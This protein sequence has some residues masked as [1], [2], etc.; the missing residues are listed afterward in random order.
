MNADKYENAEAASEPID[1]EAESQDTTP[2]AVTAESA[3]AR[4]A[5]RWPLLTIVALLLAI[6]GGAYWWHENVY[7]PN[8]SRLEANA[9][10]LAARQDSLA[11]ELGVARD[12][13]AERDTTTE[14]LR[15]AVGETSSAQ[16]E[17]RRSVSRLYERQS[18]TSV[19]WILA[20]AEYLVL[21]ASQRLALEGDVRTAVAALRAADERLRSAE[22][23]D[24]I[25]V[26]NQLIKDI[27]ALE[28]VT[29]PDVEGIALYL[30]S[31]ID[32][33]DDLP[34]KPIADEIQT[35]SE[36]Q[37]TEFSS[38]EPFEILRAMW[39]DLIGLVEVKDEQLPD[40]VLFDPEL[41]YFLQQNLKLE[42]ASARLS[43]LRVD[44][45]NL[46]ASAGLIRKLLVTYY[47][48]DDPRVESM[49]KRLDEIARVELQPGLPNISASLDMLRASR[50]DAAVAESAR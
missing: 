9:V 14:A 12:A 48:V 17:L 40:S 45:G 31:A 21:A 5:S 8:Q 23:P 25:P 16:Q 50:A 4:P 49:I 13:M 44:T 2:A 36:S 19:D 6:G 27:T 7:R 30:A 26:R 35:F 24:L 28:G 46:N 47:D 41:R 11:A 18:Q 33:V 39:R 34:T 29:L 37:A 10:D 1:D 38:E 43:V 42:L 3:P 20:E 15:S 32:T 22:H